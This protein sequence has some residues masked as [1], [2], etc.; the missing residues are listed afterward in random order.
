MGYASHA[1]LVSVPVHLCALAPDSVTPESAAYATLGAIALQGIRQ[2]EAKLGE[3][4]AVIG[5]GLVGLLTV[6]LLRAAGCTV[7]GV[8]PS[9]NA[10]K[11]A[12]ACGAA[13]AVE[14]AGAAAAGASATRGIGADAVIICA[15]TA[16]NDPLQLAGEL[17][18]SRG[19]VVMV[20]L[21]GMEVPRELFFRKELTFALSRSYGPGRYDPQYEEQGLDYPVDFVR[22]TEQRNLQAFLDL[23]AA[24]RLDTALLTTH[25]FDLA[26]A[27]RA[28]AL[29]QEAGADRAGVVLKYPG[30]ESSNDWKNGPP[31]VPTIGKTTPAG[32]GISLIG[33]GA[34][35][36]TTLMPLLKRHPGLTL[37]GVASRNGAQAA[38]FARQ[39]G[40]ASATADTSA[41][42]ADPGSRAV[43]I[44]T[45]HDAHAALAAAAL[46]AGKSVWVEKP[47]ALTLD[48]HR[49]VEAA[50]R[51]HP[52]LQLVVGFNRP[53]S[54]LAA[55]LRSTLAPQSPVMM[56]Y[57]VNAG[58]L[59]AAHWANDPAAGGGRLLG[60]GCHFLDFMR[61]FCAARPVSVHTAAVRGGRADLPATANF[62]VTT[63][64][65]DGSVGH[66]L[67]T[68][69]GSPSVAK[70]R[71][72]VSCGD[73]TG[74]L[75]D[76]RSATVC[77]GTAAPVK[78]TLKAQDK[79][80]AALL[81]SFLAA[82]DGGPPAL[83]PEALFASSLMTLAA[84][85]SLE[86][87][88]VVW[89]EDFHQQ[90]G[91]PS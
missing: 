81:A 80:Q 70:E 46:R 9:E 67:Y 19:R 26:D 88:A 91:A 90:P 54:P 83:Q 68:A 73:R 6:Q 13:L 3:G 62:A 58:A 16:G 20:G 31:G 71:F 5:L 48:Q 42:L 8:D 22:F 36:R 1:E 38:S 37:A 64:F 59:P 52:G 85:S 24:G 89:L 12:L 34:Y 63:T 35:A 76:F 21:T 40:F 84:Q 65:S 30:A 47:L 10:R 29:L 60:E 27:P 23:A 87:Q 55:W 18:R 7:I 56:C 41:V 28:Y 79:G 11:R 72:E 14:P 2:A 53:F 82:L 44:T 69:Q 57:R 45:R 43:F 32:R 51:A 77:S 4:V 74:L 39:F 66:L 49:D 50:W 61:W 33:A 17:A 75:D 86:Q 78:H 15:A 25:R